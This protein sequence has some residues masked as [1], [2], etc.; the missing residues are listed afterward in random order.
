MSYI[1]KVYRADVGETLRKEI[2]EMMII[3]LSDNA[4]PVRESAA[5][6]LADLSPLLS[7]HCQLKTYISTHL[8]RAKD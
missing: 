6:S 2:I 8:L 1:L 4:S 7:L 3:K 5:M